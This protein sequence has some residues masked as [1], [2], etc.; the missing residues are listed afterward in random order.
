MSDGNRWR[1][2]RGRRVEKQ[3]KFAP[4]SGVKHENGHAQETTNPCDGGEAAQAG[5]TTCSI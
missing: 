5:Q 2:N 3:D 4:I 1:R